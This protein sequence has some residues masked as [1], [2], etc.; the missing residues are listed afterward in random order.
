[1]STLYN[2]SVS[3]LG[4]VV[5]LM[6]NFE[7]ETSF[8]LE[9]MIEDD[10]DDEGEDHKKFGDDGL[11]EDGECEEN[12][13]QLTIDVRYVWR[14]EGKKLRHLGRFLNNSLHLRT[15]HI[16]SNSQQHT[17]SAHNRA[18]KFHGLRTTKRDFNTVRSSETILAN[19]E[20]LARTIN[21]SPVK[22][23]SSSRMKDPSYGKR[24]LPLM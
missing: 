20:Q 19:L 16:P 2:K 21:T 18:L 23:A 13:N 7:G 14:G 12:D 5:Q 1:M 6:R 15:I 4:L 22:K 10:C 17:S 24:Y 3:V 9:E 11:N 8:H